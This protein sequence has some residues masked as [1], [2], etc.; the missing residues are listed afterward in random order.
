MRAA[1][2]PKHLFKSIIRLTSIHPPTKQRPKHTLR[3]S[4]TP[5]AGAFAPDLVVANSA[6]AAAA[7]GAEWRGTFTGQLKGGGRKGARDVGAGEEDFKTGRGLEVLLQSQQK[8]RSTF[9]LVSTR[10]LGAWKAL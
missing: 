5:R 6:L 2:N 7:L 8:V 9:M 3:R 1:F 10:P 4:Q